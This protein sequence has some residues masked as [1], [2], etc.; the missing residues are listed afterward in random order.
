MKFQMFDQGF[1]DK[2]PC[3]INRPGVWWVLP[4]FILSNGQ[5]HFAFDVYGGESN[6]VT[7][8]LIGIKL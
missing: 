6:L 7:I 8:K 3:D 5:K 2:L 1:G 4:H